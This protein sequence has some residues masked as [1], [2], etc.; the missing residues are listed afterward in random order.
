VTIDVKG[1]AE[2]DRFLQQ[3]PA[4][5]EANVLRGALRAGAVVV[6]QEVRRLVP[7]RTGTLRDGIKVSTRSRRGKVTASIRATGKHAYIAHMLEFTGAAPHSI[8]PKTGRAL[9]FG[10]RLFKEVNHP[11]FQKRPFMRPALDARAQ[12]AVVQMAG[13]IKRRLASKYGLNTAD[14][15]IDPQ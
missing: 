7:V 13:Y 12:D 8:S 3:L 5:M 1:L 2:L 10:G 9:F 15:E 4:N 14:V 6:A 11:G